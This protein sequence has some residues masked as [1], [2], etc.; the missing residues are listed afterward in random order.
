[1]NEEQ[2]GPV[3]VLIGDDHSIV[4][5]AVAMQLTGHGCKIIGKAKTVEDVITMYSQLIPDV[6]VLDIKFS[7]KRTGLD[8]AKDILAEHPEAKIVFLSQN[9]QEAL[10]RETYK[11]GGYAFLTK[12]CDPSEL[13]TAVLR[14]HSGQLYFMS[15]TAEQLASALLRGEPEGPPSPLAQLDVREVEIFT[16]MA[17]GYTNEEIGEKLSLSKRTISISSQH[18]KD[19]LNLHRPAEITRLAVRLGLIEP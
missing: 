13:A 7:G 18:I 10:I 1:M 8:V 12:D 9:D 4:I 6:L 14:A 16:L 15:G 11:L 2:E 19:K 3:T 5:E 17:Q